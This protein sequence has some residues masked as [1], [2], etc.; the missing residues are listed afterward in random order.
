[1]QVGKK[2]FFNNPI[3]NKKKIVCLEL[4]SLKLFYYFYIVFDWFSHTF[5]GITLFFYDE[6]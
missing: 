3:L 1:M 6:T 2:Y 4:D 5:L